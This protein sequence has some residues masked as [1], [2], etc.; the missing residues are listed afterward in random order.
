MYVYY[1]YLDL[2]NGLKGSYQCL[3]DRFYYWSGLNFVNSFLDSVPFLICYEGCILGIRTVFK[4][5]VVTLLTNLD[6][7]L[8]ILQTFLVRQIQLICCRLSDSELQ[9]KES[10]LQSNHKF[11]AN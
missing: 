1:D 7:Y 4:V 9:L 6:L 5:Q 2:T 10:H 11:N 8:H 3:I